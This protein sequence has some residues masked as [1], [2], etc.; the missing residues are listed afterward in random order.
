M[1]PM[2]PPTPRPYPVDTTWRRRPNAV[3]AM[4][5]LAKAQNP[6]LWARTDSVARIID[7]AA[8]VDDYVFSD[9]EARA[10]T[11]SRIEYQR[12]VAMHKAQ[13]IL[14]FL[15]VNTDPDWFNLLTKLAKEKL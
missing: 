8:F 11:E 15:G 6:D 14:K 10:L 9:D 4:L 5:R 7:P 1:A 2:I 12:A 3:D 13:E